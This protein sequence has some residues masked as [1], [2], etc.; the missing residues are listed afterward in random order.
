MH[1]TGIKP[2]TVS[3]LCYTFSDLFPLALFNTCSDLF[4]Q[5]RAIHLSVEIFPG[6]EI[7]FISRHTGDLFPPYTVYR[8][9]CLPAVSFGLQ[10]F[11]HCL[12]QVCRQFTL[13][14]R[15]LSPGYTVVLGKSYFSRLLKSYF[16]PNKGSYTTYVYC[17][18]KGYL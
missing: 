7:N 3:C 18:M 12:L 9:L 4:L 17:T 10:S 11:F 16:F 2:R 13:L 15:S 14:L 1:P 6:L 5:E 8:E